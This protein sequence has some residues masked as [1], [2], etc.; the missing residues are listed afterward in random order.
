M[1]YLQF[2]SIYYIVVEIYQQ[3][4]DSQSR[5][6]QLSSNM[7]SSNPGGS[8]AASAFSGFWEN[9]KMHGQ[10]VYKYCNGL[11]TLLSVGGGSRWV[12][13]LLKR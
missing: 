1:I 12:R 5:S 9:G 10:G 3:F 8:P 11:D 2:T 6:W 7:S 13:G 4:H